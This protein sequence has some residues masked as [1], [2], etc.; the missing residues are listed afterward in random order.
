MIPRRDTLS[1]FN[2]FGP[3]APW[4]SSQPPEHP[5]LAPPFLP[6]LDSLGLLPL[7]GSPTPTA[8]AVA[9]ERVKSLSPPLLSP[10]LTPALSSFPTICW[11]SMP[12]PRPLNSIYLTIESSSPPEDQLFH[13]T[14]CCFS[15]YYLFP[16][17]PNQK[18]QSHLQ[19][20]ILLRLLLF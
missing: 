14:S 8:P 19:L 16:S 2:V 12:K 15:W 5:L 11:R 17:Y 4:S 6:L 7:H 13:E 18:P 10:G 20:L 1:P 9:Q 3:C